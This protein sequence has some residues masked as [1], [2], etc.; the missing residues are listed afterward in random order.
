MRVIAS[1]LAILLTG[2]SSGAPRAETRP[3]TV[4]AA[5]DLQFAFG[6]IGEAFTRQTGHQ[7]VFTFG[8]TGN[9]AKQ[10][11]NGAPIDLFAAAN[12]AFI[13]TLNEKGLL[14]P[15]TLQLYATGR[16]VLAS[17]RAAGPEVTDLDGLLD[18]CI[19]KVAIANPAHAPY[20][21]AA[22]EALIAAGVWDRLEPKLVYGENIRQT[23]QFIQTGNA[24][25]G[26]IALSVADVPEITYRLIDQEL[27]SPLRQA[28]AVIKGSPHEGVAREFIAFLN[29][30]EGQQT[31]QRFGFIP[32]GG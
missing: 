10:V 13:E 29:T 28:L 30:P 24:D 8:S 4:A 18:P 2:C 14:I 7:V 1:L 21:A 22:K 16:I 3:F 31:M 17:N 25:A 6:A 23:L 15:E 5:A 27:H 32:P 20:G 11:E 9:L 26:I 12:V 19:K